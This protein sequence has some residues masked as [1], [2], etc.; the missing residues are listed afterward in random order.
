MAYTSFIDNSYFVGDINI[1]NIS[2]K[3]TFIDWAIE[4]YEK[5]FLINGLGYKL[6]SLLI[7]DCT[8]KNGFPETQIYIDIVNGAEFTHASTFGEEI[9]LK[10][11][12]FN[13]TQKQSPIA[14]YVYYNILQ[15]QTIHTSDIG[16]ILLE[17]DK[18]QRVSPSSKMIDSWDKM[19]QLYGKFP[20]E[21]ENLSR[22]GNDFPI[23]N[24]APS[25]FNFLKSN[26]ANYPDWIFKPI[27]AINQFGI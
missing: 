1:P 16:T 27:G 25:L 6:Y 18:G 24:D 2:T 20:Y 12:G 4:T 5:E 3:P 11:E 10:W 13:N 22:R 26:S 19:R 17:S 9:T 23:V 8:D 7:N 14:Y 21:Y 15:H